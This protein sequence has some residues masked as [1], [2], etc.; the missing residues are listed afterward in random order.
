MN[1]YAGEDR[2]SAILN[3]YAS[4]RYYTGASGPRPLT[5]AYG[6]SFSSIADGHGMKINLKLSSNRPP[7][8]TLHRR[9]L[10]VRR[11]QSASVPLDSPPPITN[12]NYTLSPVVTHTLS[13]SASPAPVESAPVTIPRP[14]IN[15]V[16]DG[17]QIRS[18]WT[19]AEISLRADTS[20]NGSIGPED[21]HTHQPAVYVVN[22]DHDQNRMVGTT[23]VEDAIKWVNIAPNTARHADGELQ[24]QIEAKNEDW[25]LD[26]ISG[27]PDKPADN[28]AGMAP[29]QIAPIAFGKPDLKVFLTLPDGQS[30]K[31]KAFHLYIVKHSMVGGVA[32]KTHIPIWGGCHT[33]SRPPAAGSLPSGVTGASIGYGP[34]VDISKYVKPQAPGYIDTRP[35]PTPGNSQPPYEFVLEGILFKG[36]PYPGENGV[37]SYRTNDTINPVFDGFLKIGLDFR[38][39]TAANSKISGAESWVTLTCVPSIPLDATGN[40]NPAANLLAFKGTTAETTAQGYGKQAIGGRYGHVYTVTTSTDDADNINS[41]RYAIN[42]AVPRTIVFALH[43]SDGNIELGSPLFI[44]NRQCTIAGQTAFQSGGNGICLKNHGLRVTS[45]DVIVRHVRSRPGPAGGS[46]ADSFSAEELCHNVIF[47]HCSASFSNDALMDVATGRV[48]A[49]GAYY[50]RPNRKITIQ[51]CLL[52]WP[53]DRNVHVEDGELQN[54]GYGSTIRIG[55]GGKVTFWRNLYAHC[56]ARCARPGGTLDGS[57]DTLGLQLDFVNNVIY[58]WGDKG[59][60]AVEAGNEAGYDDG[61]SNQGDGVGKYNLL[62]NYY[63]GRLNNVRAQKVDGLWTTV[64]GAKKWF[65]IDNVFVNGWLAGNRIKTGGGPSSLLPGDQ[66]HPDFVEYGT[67]TMRDTFNSAPSLGYPSGIYAVPVTEAILNEQSVR[68]KA[69]ASLRRDALDLRLLAENGLGGEYQ[70]RSGTI[71]DSPAAVGGW[72]K[73]KT[74]ATPVKDFDGDGIP[75]DREPVTAG[76]YLPW[77]LDPANGSFDDDKDGYTNLEEFLTSIAQ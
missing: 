1:H 31:V 76:R 69:G 4:G 70:A 64:A 61:D 62:N 25:I 2:P 19:H 52:A 35:A 24:T 38:T 27:P 39:G 34:E 16:A 20:R 51:N 37:G 36:M 60:E 56:R 26:A 53:L 50:S 65:R 72:P 67:P 55:H 71:I 29:M 28:Q 66:W 21:Y 45:D 40:P 30:D 57:V 15:N 75:N 59:S 46:N 63:R 3:A 13:P 9:F 44:K 68:A 77:T 23:P 58:G 48:S 74:A 11:I 18:E 12:W 8:Q 32:V 54:H 7:P 73:L 6:N 5:S 17:H 10:P 22:Y 42:A 43:S 41:L 14:S 47:D 49:G 33:A